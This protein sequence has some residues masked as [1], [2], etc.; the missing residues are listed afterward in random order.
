MDLYI[1]GH[2]IGTLVDSVQ[3]DEM[4]TFTADIEIGRLKVK[5]TDVF[6][7]KQNIDE[8]GAI[9]IEDTTGE[10]QIKSAEIDSCFA[11]IYVR[12]ELPQNTKIDIIFDELK[13]KDNNEFHISLL[14]DAHSISDEHIDLKDFKIY[15]EES[16][17]L[18]S[19]HFNFQLSIIDSTKG[20]LTKDDS[21]YMK[22][23]IGKMKF[24]DFEGIIDKELIIERTE[25]DV[26]VD[27]PEDLENNI[28]LIDSLTFLEVFVDN[29]INVDSDLSMIITGINQR[30]GESSYIYVDESIIG[31]DI[32]TIKESGE[33]VT[34]LL[35]ILPSKII[36]DSIKIVVD[37]E[38]DIADVNKDDD[39]SISY[40][41]IT[42]FQFE[43]ES[44]TVRID[45]SIHIEIEPDNAE[46]I[47]KNVKRGK[48]YLNVENSFPFGA[49]VSLYFSIIEDSVFSQPELV[50]DSLDIKPAPFE[51]NTGLSTG[52]TD[53]VL[54]IDLDKN[55]VDIF[56]YPDVYL[57]LEFII[58]GSQE[59]VIAIKPDDHIT[60]IGRS[61]ID[62]YVH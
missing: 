5:D 35:E 60:I 50:I 29:N 61:V 31:G 14:V 58:E 22:I 43:L 51:L 26:D 57:G 1:S 27:Y 13:D 53:T 15:S 54:T 8:R 59:E 25:D 2:S 20:F 24:K 33:V 7:P 47:R 4:T 10:L 37:S 40:K 46:K 36:K 17:I 32:T 9:S 41:F 45:S 52:I 34:D 6:L 21:V 62:I 11:N 42:P 55:Q 23:H 3:I 12:N 18:D 49:S 38:G 28:G 16:E 48:L 19:L 56:S 44:D 39:V 30:T